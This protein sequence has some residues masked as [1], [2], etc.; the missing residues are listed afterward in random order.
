M[1]CRTPLAA[2]C[3]RALLAFAI[4]SA[5]TAAGHEDHA[6]LPSKGVTIAGDTILLSDKAREAIGLTTVKVEFGDI[7]HTLTVKAHV[8]LPWH[9]QAMIASVVS[10]TIDRVL[11]RPGETVVA[12]QELARVTSAE[13]GA[14]HATLLQAKAEAGWARKLFDQRTGLDRQG[15]IAGKTLLEAQAA[16]AQKSAALEIARQKL[17]SVGLDHTTIENVEHSGQPLPY[18]SITSPISGLISHADVRIGQRIGATDHLYHVIAPAKR[19]IVAD[20]LESDVRFLQPGQS[21]EASFVAVPNRTFTGRIDHLQLK[22]TP[23]TRTQR[24]VIAVENGSEALRP[25]MSGR[26]Q[27]SV[28]VAKD[29]IVCPVDAVVHSR[30][31][32]YLLVQR[33][34]GKYEN[35]RVTLGRTDKGRVEVLGGVFPGDRVV[36]VGTA[37]LAALLGNEHKARVADERSERVEQ[38]ATSHERVVANIDGVVELPTDRQAFAIPPAAGRIRR[39]LAEPGQEVSAGDVLAEVD[40]LAVRTL[41]LELLQVLTEA[42]LAEQALQ[43]L[44]GLGDQ[45]VIPERQLWELQHAREIR[46]LQAEAVKRQLTLFGVRPDSLSK[47]AEID[48]TQ[49]ASPLYWV[50]SVPV[51]APLTGRIVDFRVVPGQVV[52]RDEG[53]FEVHDLARVWI[54]GYVHERDA[55]QVELGQSARVHFAAYPDLETGGTV[56][57]ISP[58]MHDNEQVLPVWIE[59]ANPEHRLKQ[60]MLARVTLLAKPDGQDAGLEAGPLASIKKV[61]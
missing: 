6:P 10:G 50:Q 23:Q 1:S 15:V 57:R 56:V 19:W 13:L 33:M 12:G 61:P 43:R 52:D 20:V 27:I 38:S 31:G 11:V 34:P 24:V 45:S 39:I 54:Q 18:V 4:G 8:E 26:A 44:E 21:V 58:L 9:A 30:T 29:A 49:P 7:H 25:G 28:Q 48:L 55:A 36:S 17:A 3:R 35:R 40:S 32:A 59:V 16:L 37:L 41:Q 2:I 53:L 14:L 46:G 42:R 51:R 60:G 47:L 22:M 5:G